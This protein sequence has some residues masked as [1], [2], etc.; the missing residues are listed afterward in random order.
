MGTKILLCCSALLTTLTLAEAQQIKLTGELRLQSDSTVVTGATLLVRDNATQV[1]AKG[2]SD[3][4]GRFLIQV[5]QKQAHQLHI[6]YVG[7]QP[8]SI[9]IQGLTKHTDLGTLYLDDEATKL[10]EVAVQANLKNIDRQIIFPRPNQVKE[11][12]NI[13][14]LLGRFN[15]AGLTIDRVN[16][17]ATIK[18]KPVKWKINGIPCELAEVKSL[19]PKDILRVEYTDMPGI[20]YQD[21]GIGGIINIVVKK[22]DRGGSANAQLKSALWTGFV[23]GGAHATYNA[24]KSGFTLDYVISHRNYDKWKEDAEESYIAPDHRIDRHTLGVDGPMM[25]TIHN[26]NLNYV[27][28]AS[29]QQQFSA[30]WRNEIGVDHRDVRSMNTE[31]KIPEF[32]RSS[33]VLNRSYQPVLD[34][35]YQQG[36][37][38]GSKIEANILG[39]LTH[40]K[41]ERDLRDSRA[42]EQIY[43]FSNL[44]KS[45]YRSILGDISYDRPLGERTQ[46]SIGALYK[47]SRIR[48]T[49][50]S[51]GV[52]EDHR[53]QNNAYLYAQL[54]GSL[55]SK[56]SYELGGG[57]KF[58]TTHDDTNRRHFNV[59]RISLTMN[60]QPAQRLYLS[61]YSGLNP[62]LPGLSQLSPVEQRY[63]AYTIVSGNPDLKTAYTWWNELSAQYSHGIF[64]TSLI[65]TGV[66]QD[67]P[68]YG[69][70]SYR[71]SEKSWITHQDNGRYYSQLGAEWVGSLEG[72]FGFLSLTGK[73]GYK[74]IHYALPDM[75]ISN[76]TAYGML[77]AS[78]GFGD[79]SFSAYGVLNPTSLSGYEKVETKPLFGATASWSKGNWSVFADIYYIASPYGD[80][81]HKMNV[82]PLRPRTSV[83]TIANNKNMVTLGASWR[84]EFGTRANRSRRTLKNSDKVDGLIQVQ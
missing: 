59:G 80:Y 50:T 6:S 73:L 46:F 7:A 64:S 15:L 57:M 65:L 23:D 31:P 16:L 44:T 71:E 81:Y 32:F 8:L 47:L 26:A 10:G 28:Q 38:D 79:W 63:D 77:Y 22:R 49:Y 18:G 34:L 40:F 62:Q 9:T 36:F 51:D 66:Y 4:E 55:T 2:I 74:S 3:G 53:G 35:Y 70:I 43:S 67:S 13:F 39:T 5:D 68:F 60:Y 75:T 19:L 33:D 82:H 12:T 21:E 37:K 45:L 41:G 76:N 27:Y 48:T 29:E 42:G 17:N 56:L 54:Q 83:V 52:L 14:V 11:S 78:A 69:S 58:Y 20:R 30:S 25:Y 24:G 1:V 84:I 72:L 61:L